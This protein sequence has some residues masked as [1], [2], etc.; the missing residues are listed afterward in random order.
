MSA[1]YSPGSA[2]AFVGPDTTVVVSTINGSVRDAL[3]SLVVDGA[4]ME[5]LAA[6]LLMHA[7][8]VADFVCV[9]RGDGRLTSLV[10]GSFR[11][12]LGDG[13]EL[14]G[15]GAATGR[16]W[17]V[18][19]SWPVLILTGMEAEGESL[20]LRVGVVRAGQVTLLETLDARPPAKQ[21]ADD[22][23][24]PSADKSAMIQSAL[25]PKA[26]HEPVAEH[27]PVAE[28]DPEHETGPEPVRPGPRRKYDHHYEDSISAEELQAVVAGTPP[29]TAAQPAV[30]PRPTG[31][32]FIDAVPDF[33]NYRPQG[34]AAEPV[35]PAPAPAPGPAVHRV[36]LPTGET[37]EL[38]RPT[39][40]GREP[41]P[42]PGRE[43]TAPDLIALTNPQ[44]DISSS[45]LELRPEGEHLLAV[46]I[47]RFG[48][49]LQSP[50]TEPVR[51]PAGKPFPLVPGARLYL[52]GTLAIDYVGMS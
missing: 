13:T 42:L 19:P 18:S 11:V 43:Q 4:H 21:R 50:G 31:S 22:Q 10:R 9:R 44:R 41:A 45:H 49:Y 14:D 12:R 35:P 37:M 5:Q 24:F 39:I 32:R 33:S 28:P 47:S 1:H 25:S 51:L 7:G 30:T 52:N 6:T 29:T 16:E 20:P 27:G 8:V 2:Y 3:W 26:E 40:F 34:P 38:A 15:A 46:D 36:R 48:T 17:S 23:P